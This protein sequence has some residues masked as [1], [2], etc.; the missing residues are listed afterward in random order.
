MFSSKLVC[1][2]F[3]N[4]NNIIERKNLTNNLQYQCVS[5]NACCMR[6]SINQSLAVT[7]FV[8]KFTDKHSCLYAPLNKTLVELPVAQ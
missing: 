8:A 5:F 6:Q 4:I 7:I 3:M 2:K 1:V